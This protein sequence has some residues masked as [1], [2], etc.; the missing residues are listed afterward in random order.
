MMDGL[1]AHIF[2]GSAHLEQV[3][4]PHLQRLL[5][6][7]KKAR[8]QARAHFRRRLI[9]M[10]ND[11]TAPQVN[12]FLHGETNGFAGFNLAERTLVKSDQLCDMGTF[13]RG[14][15]NQSIP[16]AHR[17]AREGASHNTALIAILREFVHVLHGHAQWAVYQ[18]FVL[19]KG[20]Q[21]LQKRLARIPRHRRAVRSNAV[22]LTPA[23]RDISSRGDADSLE[24][25]AIFFLHGFKHGLVITDQ[26]HLIDRHDDLINAQH[27]QQVT[28]PAGVFLHAFLR[29][30]HQHRCLRM[31]SSRHHILDKFNMP[32]RI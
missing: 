4:F 24:K 1:Y 15:S 32:R 14:V 7:P 26:I 30:D 21:C 9:R 11:L 5:T 3:V 31:G 13:A 22:A 28:V 18:R 25:G 29:V 17:T 10:A 20:I 23:Q 2:L 16:G 12:L 27:A 19:F 8:A 6:N